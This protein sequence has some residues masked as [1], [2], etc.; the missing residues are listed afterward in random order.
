MRIEQLWPE[1]DATRGRELARMPRS[2]VAGWV[3]RRVKPIANCRLFA[4]LELVSGLRGLLLELSPAVLP[5]KR[6]WPRC[7]GLDWLTAPAQRGMLFGVRLKEAR[8]GDLFDALADDLA[9]RVAAAEASPASQLAALLGGVARWQKFL[10]AGA[11]GLSEEM[12]RGLWGELHFL[13]ETLLPAFSADAAVTAWQGN[14]AAHQDFLLSAGAVEVKTTSGKAPHVVRIASER[15]LDAR[16]LPALYLRHYA[17]AAR[18]GAGET[19]PAAVASIRARLASDV[20]VGESFED[21][22]LA[23][24][25]LDAHAW[26][27]ECRGYVVR[28]TNDFAVRG[29]FPRLTESDLPDGIGEIGYALSL[30][31]CRSFLLAPD[32]LLTALK[33]SPRAETRQPPKK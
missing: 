19:L 1:L 14:R 10:T 30:D 20:E 31:A 23:A 26:R 2:P 13:R 33:S 5:A 16:G 32:A 4:G 24:G 28:E 29:R 7:R 25:Y 9:R 22:L 6:R 27:Y 12:Q 8:H 17:L 21:A 11:E 18:D 15:Q 3:L